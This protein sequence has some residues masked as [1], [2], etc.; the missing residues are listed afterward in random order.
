MSDTQNDRPD[1]MEPTDMHSN[2]A[3]R[4][5]PVDWNDAQSVTRWWGAE[6]QRSHRIMS[7]RSTRAADRITVMAKALDVWQRLYKLSGDAEELKQMKTEIEA[8]RAEMGPEQG[9]KRVK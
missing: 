6:I 7:S 2:P 9:I 1:Y 4:L 5:P 8:L 3:D